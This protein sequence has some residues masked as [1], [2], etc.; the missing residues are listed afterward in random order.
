MA[1]SRRE[2]ENQYIKINTVEKKHSV[3]KQ[4]N[5]LEMFV[6]GNIFLEILVSFV[7]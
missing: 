3:E 5:I 4:R 1:K 7:W 6:F 2:K